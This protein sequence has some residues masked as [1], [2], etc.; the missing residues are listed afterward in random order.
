MKKT[1]EKLMEQTEDCLKEYC[2]KAEWTPQ[3]LESL[4]RAVKTYDTLQSIL[5]NNGIWAE[6]KDD[7]LRDDHSS[8][9]YPTIHYGTASYARGRDAHTGRYVSRRN[10]PYYDDGVYMEEAWRHDGMHSS[11]SISDQMV[12]KLEALMDQAGSEYEREKVA[13]VIKHIEQKG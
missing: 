11:H 8:R 7:V 3:D 13:E 1:V 10:R 2:K 4:Y 6:I 5:M 9:T 12:Q